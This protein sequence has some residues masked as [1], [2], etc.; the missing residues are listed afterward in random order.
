M[1]SLTR[2]TI[3]TYQELARE[4]IANADH[5]AICGGPPTD[6]DPFECDHRVP[7]AEGGS[8]Q[9]ENLQAAH[10]TC[11]RRAGAS[12]AATSGPAARVCCS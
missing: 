1:F 12:L 5:C 11:N 7:I 9:R 3:P 2:T 4:I 10:R 8:T 6:T